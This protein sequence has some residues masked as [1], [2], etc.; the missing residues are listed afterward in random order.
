MRPVLPEGL[1]G[2]HRSRGEAGTWMSL[3]LAT[4]CG[5]C[6]RPGRRWRWRCA[7]HEH[8]AH[9]G[10][11]RHHRQLPPACGGAPAALDRPAGRD[12]A[13]PA[14]R[15]G[16]DAGADAARARLP[17]RARRHGGLQPQPA[18]TDQPRTAGRRLSF[19]RGES[20]HTECAYKP[21]PERF[22]AWARLGGWSV[23]R[24]WREG[25]AGGY[26]FLLLHL[27]AP[28][29]TRRGRRFPNHSRSPA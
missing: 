20:I 7:M 25:P 21:T 10:T 19:A 1:D 12:A 22:E 9:L 6:T 24:Q 23:V 13:P 11:F 27:A 18:A 15:R 29:G 8:T 26:A 5:P 16:H 14:D 4:G 17:G 3:N 28:P 2:Q